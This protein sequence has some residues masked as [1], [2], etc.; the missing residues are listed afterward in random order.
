MNRKSLENQKKKN[1]GNFGC[2]KKR[3]Q[4]YFTYQDAAYK[5]HRMSVIYGIQP[6]IWKS[7]GYILLGNSP[8][9]T[10]DHQN[11]T[12]ADYDYLHTR[13]KNQSHF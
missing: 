13:H 9:V 1:G 2:N 6:E 7:Y 3:D 10:D 8:T 5:K 4:I 12:V 11:V